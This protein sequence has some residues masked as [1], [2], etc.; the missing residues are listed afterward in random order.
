MIPGVCE[1]NGSTYRRFRVRKAN[2]KGYRDIYV[3]LPHPTH[4]DFSAALAKLNS[5]QIR[6]VADFGSMAALI[7]EYRAVLADKK[8][9]D[10]TREAWHYYLGLMVEQ[11]GARQVELLERRHVIRIRD[12]MATTPG[13]ANNYIAKLRGL[14]EYAIDIGWIKS[15]PARGVSNLKTGEHEPWPAHVLEDAIAAADPML[16][17]AIITGACS[18]QRLSDVIKM[19]FGWIKDGIMHVRSKK[20]RTDAYIPMHALWLA[21]IKKVERKAV[22]LLYD[23]S[24]KPFSDTD[25]VQERLRR[26]MHGLGYV[27]DDGQLLYT[28]HG[29]GKNACCYL[30]EIGLTQDEVAAIVGKTPQT[31]AHYSKRARSLMI[32][33][34]AA[35]RATS[36]EIMRFGAE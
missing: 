36:G 33:K 32:A 5:K 30:I 35:D 18:G 15:N 28:F 9:A 10:A 3:K 12:S 29:L 25:R 2:G 16:R 1:K 14:L 8:M 13:K 22:T 19:Q 24:G 4:P 31:V 20:T 17:L 7:K 27:D 26:L 23:R 6:E 34:G 11:H 21:E